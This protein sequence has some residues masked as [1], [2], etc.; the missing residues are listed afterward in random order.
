MN[1]S[2]NNSGLFGYVDLSKYVPSSPQYG[3]QKFLSYYSFL[4]LISNREFWHQIEALAKTDDLRMTLRGFDVVRGHGLLGLVLLCQY[5]LRK[6]RSVPIVEFPEDISRLREPLKL[7]FLDFCF[8]PACP[9]EISNSALIERASS[10]GAPAEVQFPLGFSEV[11]GGT[12]GTLVRRL[13]ESTKLGGSLAYDMGWGPNDVE[14][15]VEAI[16]FMIVEVIRNVVM[17]SDAKPDAG[18]GY[19]MVEKTQRA[20][21]ISVGDIGVGIRR[22]LVL[23]REVSGNDT[24]AIEQALLYRESIVTCEEDLTGLFGILWYVKE[25]GGEL[26]IRSD[27]SAVRLMSDGSS[28]VTGDLVVDWIG[29]SAHRYSQTNLDFGFPGTQL[30]IEIRREKRQ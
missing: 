11:N 21:A 1:V 29:N 24:Q 15:N 18:Y 27:S 30:V 6:Y 14:R 26:L 5:I 20:L 22:S 19:L 13:Q 4:S 28:S 9:F 10:V 23:K 17:H 8:S 2:E 16:G 12:I 25:I 3:N 7:R